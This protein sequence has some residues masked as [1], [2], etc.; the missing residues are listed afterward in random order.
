MDCSP[1]VAD[2]CDKTPI[3]QDKGLHEI[4]L[5]TT[6]CDENVVPPITPLADT[7]ALNSA[8][9]NVDRP[10]ETP[11]GTGSGLMR[12]Q[13]KAVAKTRVSRDKV[14]GWLSWT[15]QKKVK[16]SK[17][18]KGVHINSE[19]CPMETQQEGHG[20]LGLLDGGEPLGPNKE[21][22][23]PTDP[24][25]VPS[26]DLEEEPNLI[27]AADLQPKKLHDCVAKDVHISSEEFPM[28]IQQEGHG[29]LGLL[30]GG[31]SSGPNKEDMR[32][33][34]PQT[35]P[36]ID[37][38]EEPNLIAAADLQPKK[39]HDCVAKGTPQVE[40]DKI[41]RCSTEFPGKEDVPP[42]PPD[43]FECINICI[44]MLHREP[45]RNLGDIDI[46]DIL[47]MKGIELL[48]PRQMKMKEMRLRSSRRDDA[49]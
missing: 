40:K 10:G 26:T 47:K 31:E 18:P 36:S 46:L 11:F 2:E 44:K 22:M 20:D 13:K 39:L 24:Q 15:G 29:D 34:D 21:D 28:E 7:I 12:R 19:E 17:K 37:L 27:A 35:V 1:S 49:N 38:E 6:P 4:S 33:M 16:V 45:R 23:R 25:T 3:S 9:V 41:T 30:D 42:G 32:P 8:T 14:S 48:T 43:L 5:N